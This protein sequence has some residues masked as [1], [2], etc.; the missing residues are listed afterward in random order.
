MGVGHTMHV[1]RAAVSAALSFVDEFE[2]GLKK[3]GT[4]IND[5]LHF[6]LPTSLAGSLNSTYGAQV[7]NVSVRCGGH[8]DSIEALRATSI[9]L[10]EATRGLSRFEQFSASI[11]NTRGVQSGQDL[12]CNELSSVIGEEQLAA[13]IVRIKDQSS[14][15]N[16]KGKTIE[17][18]GAT[19]ETFVA[20]VQ[21]SYPVVMA[22]VKNI[23]ETGKFFR[24]VRERQKKN[25]L[26]VAFTNTIGISRRTAHNYIQAYEKLGTR[27]GDFSYLGVTKLLTVT[28]VKEPL[29]YLEK[30][31]EAI[32]KETTNEVRQRVSLETAKTAVGQNSK[33]PRHAVEDMGYLQIKAIAAANGRVLKLT[34][35]DKETQEEIIKL[36]KSHFSKKK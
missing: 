8:R 7:I 13:I 25:R 17:F 34:G 10:A 33:K 19:R 36:L 18:S 24:E 22:M 2:A 35:L 27:M 32:A 3:H 26:W 5:R 4:V 16:D 28:R 14:I 12:E 21:N 6:H 9:A 23:F 1:D 31:A 30:N 11:Q 15:K 29:E 20:D